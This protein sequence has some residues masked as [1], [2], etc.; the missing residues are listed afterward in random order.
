MNLSIYIYAHG[1]ELLEPIRLI[2]R[3]GLV[4]NET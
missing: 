1:W 3:R 2:A 4:G